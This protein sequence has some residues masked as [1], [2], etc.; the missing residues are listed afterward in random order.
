MTFAPIEPSPVPPTWEISFSTMW[1]AEMCPKEV[2]YDMSGGL[3]NLL[4]PPYLAGLLG[5]AAHAMLRDIGPRR[6]SSASFDKNWTKCLQQLRRAAKRP[7]IGPLPPPETWPN[8]WV[9]Y[10]RLRIRIV[11][12][13]VKEV[14]EFGG[15]GIPHTG[16]PVEA[17]NH[18]PMVERTLRDSRLH[19]VGTPDFVYENEQGQLCIRD[20][21]TGANLAHEREA[22]QLHFYAHLVQCAGLKPSWGEID[23]LRG[24]P[25]RQRIREDLIE[26]VVRRAERAREAVRAHAVSPSTPETC[27]RCPYSAICS[28]SRAVEATRS[29][30]VQGRVSSTILNADGVIAGL[31]IDSEAGEV[32]VGGLEDRSM[33]IV[34]GDRVLAVGLRKRSVGIGLLADWAT[35]V[36]TEKQLRDTLRRSPTGETACPGS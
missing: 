3:R 26:D 14:L 10:E 34:A 5:N 13:S 15:D 33:T 18:L 9:T 28:D 12:D 1:Q 36:V 27:T 20:Y 30:S 8:Y 2:A 22:A 29:K 32:V 11:D 7:S 23:R 21:K 19:L 16:E 31:R 35:V 17:T 4:R 25:E 24:A 6:V